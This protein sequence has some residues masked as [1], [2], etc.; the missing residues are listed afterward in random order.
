MNENMEL[1]MHLYK[2]SEMGVYSTT[3]LI[4]NLKNR[5]NKIKLVLE[6]EIKEYE[7]F[8]KKSEKYLRKNKIEPEG[9][10]MMTKVSSS[11]GIKMETLK[12]NSDAA[13]AAML[14]EGFTMGEIEL[15]SK[16]DSYKKNCESKYLKLCKEFVKFQKKEIEK[17]KA[18]I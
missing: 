14:I 11:M 5:D 8:L 4:N 3:C 6:S 12:D 2:A 15:H 7:Y 10:S 9:T 18:F 16:V 13:I 1:M 17:L